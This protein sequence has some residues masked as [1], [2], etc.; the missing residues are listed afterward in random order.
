MGSLFEEAKLMEEIALLET[1]IDDMSPEILSYTTEKL[2]ESGALDTYCTPVYMKKGR[3]GVLLSVLTDASH[4]EALVD[5]ILSE[6]TTIGVRRSIVSR[7]VM[8]RKFKK[9]PTEYGH[10]D[11]K[12]AISKDIHKFSPEYE[13]CKEAAKEYNVPLSKVYAAVNEKYS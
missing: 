11:V 13:Q 4:E 2:L 1:N 5:I 12:V 7:Y 10:I 3:P 6:T 8:E 9:I